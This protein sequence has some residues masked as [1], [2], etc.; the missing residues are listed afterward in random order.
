MYDLAMD[1]KKINLYTVAERVYVALLKSCGS[2][3]SKR[4]ELQYSTNIFGSLQGIQFVF[5]VHHNI[6]GEFTKIDWQNIKPTNFNW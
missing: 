1:S 5:R 2:I 6:K 4:L 3:I